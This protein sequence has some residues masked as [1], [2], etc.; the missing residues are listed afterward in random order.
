MINIITGG[1]GLVG[2]RLIFDLVSR[3]EKVSV[4]KRKETSVDKLINNL[5]FY[6]DKPQK[7]IK[8]VEFFDGEMNDFESLMNFI[9][10]GANVY[11]CAAKV[12]FAEQDK[13]EIFET[14]VEGTQNL[15]NV[16]LEKQ[17]NKLCFVSSI[18]TLGGKINGHKIDENT[19]WAATGK[20]HYSLSKYEAEMEVWK[21]VAE[22]L[23]AVIVNPGV[24]LGPG[25]WNNGSS[26][27]FST[28]AKGLM[29]YTKGI[30]SYVDVRD[31][32]K[33]MILL[34][35]SDISGER[36]IL[37]SESLSYEMLFKKI[38]TALV[39]KSPRFYANSFVTSVGWKASK[40]VSM[41]TRKQPRLTKF[42][43]R[44]AHKKNLYD[45]SKISNFINYSYTPID[46]TIEF[47]A[48]KYLSS[49]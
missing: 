10:Q 22:G 17:V 5:A 29:F 20:S 18:A 49:R 39:V 6:S 3:G 31:V 47:V 4:I 43:H 44:A 46:E 14:N 11:H 26:Q 25:D 40:L 35:D 9:P 33:A 42:S 27:I 7:L 45:G 28:L 30:T 23:N 34:M 12:S 38:A 41:I 2:S 8:E 48:K 1:T 36:F 19:P 32:T 16:C 37:S 13:Q 24:I 21:G 15:V